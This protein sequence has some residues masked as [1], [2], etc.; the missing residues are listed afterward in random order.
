MKTLDQYVKEII[1]RYE[2]FDPA[3]NKSHARSVIK[4]SEFIAERLIKDEQKEIDKD[5]VKIVAAMHDLGLAY[6]RETHHLKS[7]EIVR[8]EKELRNFFNEYEIEL[9]AKAVEE[10]RAS[11]KGN[12]T[13]IYS[14][15]VSDA[16]RMNTAEEYI[17]RTHD[18]SRV[19]YPEMNER[20]LYEEV[21]SH[22]QH[23][24]GKEG[25]ARFNTRYAEEVLLEMKKIIVDTEKLT[26]L[27]N[28][29][30]GTNW[31]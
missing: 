28:E 12:Y 17:K 1:E 9:I 19:H 6:D 29:M 4:N 11:Y 24:Y 23:K 25:Y 8:K 26:N 5:I 14:M 13:S 16:D 2:N 30:Y 31:K 3:H 27:Y 18:W 15:I 21:V 20:E 7:G 10:H 22:L